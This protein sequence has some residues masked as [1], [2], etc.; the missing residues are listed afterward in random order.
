MTPPAP[1]FRSV[2]ATP[3]DVSDD[4]LIELS[5]DLGIP[6]LV[7]PEVRVPETPAP[8]ATAPSQKLPQDEI[9][10][11][12]APTPAPKLKK[13]ATSQKAMPSVDPVTGPSR[14]VSIDIPDQ[15]AEQLRKRAFE[16]RATARYFLL[17]GLKAIGFDIPDTELVRDARREE[18][19]N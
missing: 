13:R 19:R 12:A 2:A 6:A 11:V 3:L 15:V 17:A 8:Q 14:R 7:K 9:A 1:R 16:E 10:V 5:D 18:F 4:E